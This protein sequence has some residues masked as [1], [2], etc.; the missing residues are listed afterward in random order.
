MEVIYPRDSRNDSVT[1]GTVGSTVPV[2]SGGVVNNTFYEWLTQYFNDGNASTVI[3]TINDYQQLMPDVGLYDLLFAYL[4]KIESELVKLRETNT[5]NSDRII[6]TLLSHHDVIDLGVFNWNGNVENIFVLSG[7]VPS[8]ITI[9]QYINNICGIAVFGGEFNSLDALTGLVNL[10][11][12]PVDYLDFIISSLPVLNIGLNSYVPISICDITINNNELGDQIS[13]DVQITDD[14]SDEPFIPH[15][16]LYN[17]YII[18][19]AKK[20]SSSDDWR[21]FTTADRTSL[22]NYL[23]VEGASKLRSTNV[24][25]WDVTVLPSTDDY[26][27]G[28]TG[29]GK[30]SGFDGVSSAR[31][32]QNFIMGFNGALI[33]INHNTDL[34]VDGGISG[35]ED[36]VT[37]RLVRDAPGVVDG[38]EV[39]Y[40]GN[41]G[42]VYDAVAIN[43]LYW[44]KPL[45]ETKWRTGAD[46]VFVQTDVLWAA[47][48]TAAYTTYNDEPLNDNS[49]GAITVVSESGIQTADVS[50][51]GTLKPFRDARRT[52][53]L[54]SLLLRKI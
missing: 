7:G 37:I 14:I 51:T 16:Y 24:A 32:S 53:G 43:G 29:A 33:L 8:T 12:Y 36:A 27:F 25:V 10:S 11:L 42:K 46:M 4:Q 20:V 15:G 44:T 39:E 31:L 48:S 45:Q 21:P 50:N 49:Q 19:D 6:E 9:N 47:Q 38:S 22:I 35:S 52:T 40:I 34:I 17:K 1:S 26:G 2:V 13:D 54:S 3:E 18:T 5:V 23:G 41:D 30:R 28:A